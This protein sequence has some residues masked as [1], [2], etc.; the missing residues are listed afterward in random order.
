MEQIITDETQQPETQH[1]ARHLVKHLRRL[2]T[3]ILLE[4]WAKILHRVNATN[5]QLQKASLDINT[6]VSLLESLF[7]FIASLRDSF[8]EFEALGA[9]K[10]R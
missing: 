6:S 2:E 5:L 1:E 3:T 8:D 7:T 10:N 9:K 4:L